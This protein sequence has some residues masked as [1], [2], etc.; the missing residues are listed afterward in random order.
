[1]AE[2]RKRMG[3]LDWLVLLVAF[4]CLVVA[5]WE[6]NFADLARRLVAEVEA[7][8]RDQAAKR[9]P[10]VPGPPVVDYDEDRPPLVD[11]DALRD[12]V[13]SRAGERVSRETSLPESAPAVDVSRETEPGPEE[14]S[15]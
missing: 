12:E 11:L 14:G 7:W 3:S 10:Y 9:T 1:M 4:G 8:N 6:Y 13:A 5:A 2:T 15:Q